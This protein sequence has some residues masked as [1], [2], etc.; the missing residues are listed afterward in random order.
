MAAKTRRKGAVRAIR[1]KPAARADASLRRLVR[2]LAR[3]LLAHGERVATAESC[4][5]GWI[6]KTLTDVAGSSEWFE[7]G[8]VTYS[9]AAKQRRLGVSRR[10]LEREGAVSEAVVRAM[11]IGALRGSA[12]TRAVAVSGIAGPGGAVVGKPVGTVW[13]CWAR[14]RVRGVRIECELHHFRGDRDMVRRK[15]VRHALLGLLRR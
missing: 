2:R 6:A 10:L 11:A 13:L 9:Y 5:G 1:G 8:L 3:E 4:T 7:E 14:R 12:A 15:T